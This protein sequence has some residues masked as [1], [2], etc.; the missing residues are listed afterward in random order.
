MKR[1][2]PAPSTH[3]WGCL[4][5]PSSQ[6]SPLEWQAAIFHLFEDFSFLFMWESVLPFQ[7]FKMTH[8]V[9]QQAQGAPAELP[10]WQLW[11]H[12][13]LK[14]WLVT[15]RLGQFSKVGNV[16]LNSPFLRPEVLLP[17]QNKTSNYGSPAR[18]SWLQLFMYSR[19]P[20]WFYWVPQRRIGGL[21]GTFCSHSY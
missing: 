9:V 6:L 1:S 17:S 5:S 7:W 16:N 15:W 18:K 19:A 11:T 4:E 21:G 3:F 2:V 14:E 12:H 20:S 13:K 8:W 10:F